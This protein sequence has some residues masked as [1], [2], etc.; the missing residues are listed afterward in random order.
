VATQ[1]AFHSE[2]RSV[3]RIPVGQP[4]RLRPN[5]WSTIEVCV[6]NISVAGFGARCDTLLRM[7][8]YVALD[9]PGIGTVDARTA[10]HRG[11]DF[12]A[13]FVAPIDL[14]QCEWF[15]GPAEAIAAPDVP[16]EVA[17]LANALAERV[18]KPRARTAGPNSLLNVRIPREK[19]PD[20]APTMDQRNWQRHFGLVEQAELACGGQTVIANVVN[21][22]RSGFMVE[23][24]LAVEV[25]DS[26]EVSIPDLG[27]F[28]AFVRWA[29]DGAVGLSLSDDELEIS[30]S[31]SPTR[32]V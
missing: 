24:D 7:D 17:S 29:K 5:R 22:S 26:V 27:T 15:A 32:S 30:K 16:P 9:I 14:R 23:T 28:S 8:Q 18:S 20:K 2:R 13:K 21:I 25:G 12:G 31:G 11:S 10:W 1:P 19:K 4:A 3:P 6:L